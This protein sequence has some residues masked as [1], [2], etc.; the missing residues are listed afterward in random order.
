MMA[1][2]F[3]AWVFENTAPLLKSIRQ[4]HFYKSVVK[5]DLESI[6]FIVVIK[7]LSVGVYLAF[8]DKDKE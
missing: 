6:M 7:Y 1:F 8:K 3:E 2:G 4:N 5:S